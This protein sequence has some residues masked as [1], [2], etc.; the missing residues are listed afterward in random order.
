[1]DY[2]L[3]RIETYGIIPVISIDHAD[4]AVPLARAL[5]EGCLPV[6]EITFRTSEGEKS[7][8]RI[9]EEIP[10]MLVGAGTILT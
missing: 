7:I 8:A 6:A 4:H 1:M 3:K 9:S 10:D 2:I 5:E